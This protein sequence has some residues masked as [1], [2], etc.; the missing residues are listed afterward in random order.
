MLFFLCF[1]LSVIKRKLLDGMYLFQNEHIYVG[2]KLWVSVPHAKKIAECE[3]YERI[4]FCWFQCNCIIATGI[5]F[6]FQIVLLV[7]PQ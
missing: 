3:S 5:Y 6:V 7:K 4:T 2:A 1:S